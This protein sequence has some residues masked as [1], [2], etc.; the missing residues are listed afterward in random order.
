MMTVNGILIPID[1]V[2]AGMVTSDSIIK[3]NE[4]G[5][6]VLA[7]KP[8][9]ELNKDA[10][11]RLYRHGIKQI[12][13]KKPAGG[14]VIPSLGIT[15]PPVKPIMDSAV[16]EKA[17][18]GVRNL[19]TLAESGTENMTTAYQAIKELDHVVDQLVDTISSAD[20]DVHISDLKSYDEYTYHHSLSV[21]VLAIAIGKGMGFDSAM[22]KRLGHAAILHDIGKLLVPLEII[23]KPGK[24]TDEEFTTIQQHA[25]EGGNYFRNANIGDMELWTAIAYHHE[26]I[27][28]GGYPRGLKGEEIP[29]LSRVISVADVY[30][31]L[32]SYRSYRKPMLPAHAVEIIMGEVGKSF[33]YDVVSTFLESI[34]LY[35]IN[36]VLE[37]SDKRQGVVIDNTNSMRPILRMLDDGSTLDLLGK[38]NLS[39]MVTVVMDE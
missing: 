30:D 17:I 31:A 4:S 13:V 6:T 10:I 39:L 2:K 22:L 7:I 11:E 15:V 18:S 38:D 28:G 12:P 37:L 32:T 1:K 35:P 27:N 9:T 25:E 16:K 21:A 29:L 3:L 33:F 14:I 5:Q 26:K 20:A 8:N 19:F 23:N 24:L 34:K 36:T